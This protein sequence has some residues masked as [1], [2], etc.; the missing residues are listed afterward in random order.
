MRI[1]EAAQRLGVTPRTIKYHED[2][3]SVSPS[4][5]GGNYRDYSE[6][7]LERVERSRNLQRLG[8]SL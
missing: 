3:G 5:T 1:R 8:L 7:D 2:L 4:R 6:D